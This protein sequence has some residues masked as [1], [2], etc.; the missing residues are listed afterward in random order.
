MLSI[1]TKKQTEDEKNNKP[2]ELFLDTVVV[3]STSVTEKWVADNFI[4]NETHFAS[5]TV[6]ED[7]GD[8]YT[9][10]RA[11]ITYA[12]AYINAGSYEERA[13]IALT[14]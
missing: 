9:V 6:Y 10:V 7:D 11:K 4:G 8:T 12:A 5:R 2:A 3:S 13:K 14:E 1:K